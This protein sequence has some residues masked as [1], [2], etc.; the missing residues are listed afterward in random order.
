MKRANLQ[1]T[2][3]LFALA[4]MAVP[5]NVFGQQKKAPFVFKNFTLSDFGDGIDAAQ[6]VVW[7]PKFSEF[8][9]QVKDENQNSANQQNTQ[10]D[11]N[12]VVVLGG[13]PDPNVN[14]VRY[15]EGVP[16]GVTELVEGVQ[17]YVLGVKAQFTQQGYNWIELYPYRTDGQT[18]VQGL[19]QGNLGDQ[20]A[21]STA[22]ATAVESAPDPAAEGVEYRIP[23]RGYATDVSMWVWGGYY[24]WWVELYVRDYLNY[25]YQFPMG[26]L[27]YSGWKQKRINIPTSIVQ[28]RK[29]LPSS[30]ALSFEKIKIWSFP[31][32]LVNQFYVY[33]D[34]LQHGSVIDMSVFNGQNLA[35]DIW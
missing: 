8:A 22:T 25:D 19:A 10:S 21:A 31:T 2:L 35:E 18:N 29:R 34:L 28:T 11:T 16:E 26:D 32:E 20:A 17:K 1:R 7:K 33:F 12:T 6:A 3:A 9:V 5:F 13:N 23:F 14:A 30:Q 4:A 15:A 27:L 24:G